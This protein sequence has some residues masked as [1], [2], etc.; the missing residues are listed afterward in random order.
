M[1]VA[2]S[3]CVAFVVAAFASPAMAHPDNGTDVA[4]T[5]PAAPEGESTG[6]RTFAIDNDVYTFEYSYPAAVE[7][8]PKLKKLLDVD[9]ITR[10]GKLFGEAT[11]QRDY[12]AKEG[13]P[14]NPFGL[15]MAW[16]VAG[17]LPNWLSLSASYSIYQG[18]AH[19]NHGYEA[20][21]WD[22]R[23]GVQ[24]D[25]ADLFL[26]KAAL[27]D[28]LREDFCRELDRQRAEK[29]E[30]PPEPGSDDPFDECIDPVE[31]TVVPATTNGY[32]FTQ[33][34]ILVPPY[35]AG[36]YVEGAYEVTL[37][38]NARILAAVRPEYRGSFSAGH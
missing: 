7:A 36:P 21:L 23:A 5:A 11:E 35:A 14:Y 19:P 18:G 24:R 29:R 4:N 30:R 3:V 22:R 1:N 25:V 34:E 28:A 38:V 20:L 17:E 16:G 6:G 13:Y 8:D 10:K 27:S 31:S 37:P 9:L 33:I 32:A 26:S 15:W 12:A 2:R